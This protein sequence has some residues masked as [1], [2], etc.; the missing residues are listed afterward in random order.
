MSINRG[1]KNPGNQP[2]IDDVHP[3]FPFSAHAPEKRAYWISFDITLSTG[4]R[5]EN[6]LIASCTRARPK[7]IYLCEPQI[8][9]ICWKCRCNGKNGNIA[10]TKRWSE[11]NTKRETRMRFN[12]KNKRNKEMSNSRKANDLS[13]FLY[14][15]AF[16][17]CALCLERLFL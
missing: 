15:F 10:C 4:N 11:T 1:V 14:L 5:I 12:S 9:S 3:P 16:Y 17:L 6:C 2:T 13:F 8:R 7:F